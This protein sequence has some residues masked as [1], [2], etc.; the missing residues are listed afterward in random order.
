MEDVVY[1]AERAG[2]RNARTPLAFAPVFPCES[3]Q[4]GLDPP[5]AGFRHISLSPKGRFGLLGTRS[6]TQCLS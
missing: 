6:R 5:G 1:T 2:K 4:V 3:R